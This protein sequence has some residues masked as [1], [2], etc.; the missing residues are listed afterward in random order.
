MFY[1]IFNFYSFKPLLFLI[2]NFERT[3]QFIIFTQMSINNFF[4]L[5]TFYQVEIVFLSLR[6]Y[7]FLFLVAYVSLMVFRESKL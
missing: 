1:T 4:I 3:E 2:L 6:L 5:K 7:Q